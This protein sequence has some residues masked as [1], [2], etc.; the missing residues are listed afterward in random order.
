MY[1]DIRVRDTE[2]LSYPLNFEMFRLVEGRVV[3]EI[4]EYSNLL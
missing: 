3:I 2:S 4:F 1:Y